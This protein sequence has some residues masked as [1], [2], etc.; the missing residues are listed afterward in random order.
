MLIR[1]ENVHTF[2]DGEKN[3]TLKGITLSIG[4]GEMVCVM[5]PNGAG[6]TTLLE[7]ING[8]LPATGRV[9]VF[10]RDARR[11]GPEIRK[12]IGYMLQ[13]KTFPE[14]T[15]YLVRD[16]VLMGRFGKIGM[17]RR[18]GREDWNAA[19]DAAR[20]MEVDHLWDRP[21]GKLSGGQTQR[22]LLARLLAKNPRILLL[23]EPYSNLDCRA[24]EDVSRK[25][26]ILHE[27]NK[28]TT[29]MVIHDTAHVPAI[30]DRILLLKDGRLIGDAHPD[31]MLSSRTF[32][33]AF[34]EA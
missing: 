22:V 12:D 34:A 18:P 15:P 28:L 4:A 27:R 6:K 20:F 26:C 29:V 17:L 33:D 5:G 32:R 9:E 14:D 3:S 10:G 21:I 16:V 8:I 1:L 24:V 2:Y 23:D 25:I 13:A 31:E 30:C 11:H 7:T 19:R